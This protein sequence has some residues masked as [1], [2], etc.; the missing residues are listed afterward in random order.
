MVHIAI[1]LYTNVIECR[2]ISNI[3][4]PGIQRNTNGWLHSAKAHSAS[5][6]TDTCVVWLQHEYN[7][8]CTGTVI[9]PQ[10]HAESEIEGLGEIDLFAV[11]DASALVD[12]FFS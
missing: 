4:L 11:P 5:V 12:G 8:V 2:I 7:T 9:A 1:C 6:I 10:V 3:I